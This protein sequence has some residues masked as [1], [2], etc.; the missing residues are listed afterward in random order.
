MVTSQRVWR[1]PAVRVVRERNNAVHYSLE[2]WGQ[3]IPLGE[4]GSSERV[5]S[6]ELDA[7]ICQ[8]F[9]GGARLACG[10]LSFALSWI[11][12]PSL[13]LSILDSASRRRGWHPSWPACRVLTGSIMGHGHDGSSFVSVPALLY[14]SR[15]KGNFFPSSASKAGDGLTMASWAERC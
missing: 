2:S 8:P 12:I 7:Q 4:G 3:L 5:G 6:Q 11:S 10:R 13:S 1:P 14:A 9:L 15:A